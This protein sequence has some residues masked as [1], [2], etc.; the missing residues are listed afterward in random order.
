M[1]KFLFL[2]LNVH[3]SNLVLILDLV[4]DSKNPSE[5]MPSNA[6][7]LSIE[8][9][10][11]YPQDLCNPCEDFPLFYFYFLICTFI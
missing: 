9:I 2:S 6:T 5:F 11:I 4:H 7:E 3:N 8:V 1:N 10:L